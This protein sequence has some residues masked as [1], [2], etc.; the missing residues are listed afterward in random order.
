MQSYEERKL[1]EIIK[2]NGICAVLRYLIGYTSHQLR[3]AQNDRGGMMSSK[4][5][6]FHM[7]IKSVLE[8]LFDYVRKDEPTPEGWTDT[9]KISTEHFYQTVALNA[10]NPKM[11]AESFR[12]FVVNTAQIVDAERLPEQPELESAPAMFSEI[13]RT[14]EHTYKSDRYKYYND[15]LVAWRVID[16]QSMRQPSCPLFRLPIELEATLYTMLYYDVADIMK[17]VTLLTKHFGLTDVAIDKKLCKDF[18]NVEDIVRFINSNLIQKDMDKL[19]E[20]A[21]N[22]G[23]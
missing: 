16:A 1:M 23:C 7:K 4:V 14:G 10:T 6:A 22:A 2:G 21:R 3:T 5:N 18:F 15:I 13:T 9:G 12:K 20:V 19:K 11:D 17:L 8:C